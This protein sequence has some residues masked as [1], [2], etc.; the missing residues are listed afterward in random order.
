MN[1]STTQTALI[2][3]GIALSQV[4]P[5]LAQNSAP[6]GE[7]KTGIGTPAA[8]AA[9]RRPV[10]QDPGEFYLTAYRLC[11]E[12]EMLAS[13]QSYNAALRKGQQAEKVLAVIVRDFPHW[14]SNLV[15]TRRRIL[16]E[17]MAEY[18]RKAAAAPIPTGR[19]PGKPLDTD[20]SG[21][22]LPNRPKIADPTE[23]QSD[24]KPVELPDYES[25]DKDMYNALARAQE[26]CRRMAEAYKELNTR[27]LD[28]QKKLN[29]A[30]LDQK[31]YQDRYNQLQDQIK[32]ERAAGNRVVDALSQQLSELEAKYRAS[33]QA[34]KEA[35]SR[36]SELESKLAQTQAELER[37]TKERD[38]LKAENEQLRAIVE[39]NSPEKTKALLDQN[40][41]LAEQLKA[42]QEKVAQLESMQAGSD[43]QNAVLSRQL[44]EARNEAN[45][46]RDEMSGI[47]DENMGYR[48]RISELS[49]RLNNLEADLEAQSDQP[50]VD[51]ALAEENKLL[52]EVIAKQKRTLAMQEEGRKLLVETYMQIK[53][54]DPTMLIALKKLEEESTL[55]LTDAEKRIMESVKSAEVESS[56]SGTEGVDAVRRSLEVETLATLAGK[57]FAKGRYTSAEQLYRTLYDCQPDHVAGLVNLGTILLYRNKCEEAISFLERASRLAP[58]L[59]ITYYLTGICYYRMDKMTEAQKMFMRTVELDPGNAEAFFYLA[60][61]EGVNGVFDRALK[62][63]AAAIKL[64]PTLGDAHY[65]MARLYAEMSQIPD[66]ARAYDRAV[67]NGAEPDPEFENYLRNH[68]DNAKAPGVDLVAEVQPDAE[69]EILRKEDPEMEK[70]LAAREQEAAEQQADVN[71]QPGAEPPPADASAEPQPAPEQTTTPEQEPAAPSDQPAPPQAA[72]GESAPAG[73]PAPPAE[74]TPEQIFAGVVS[75]IQWDAKSAPSPSPAGAGHETDKSRFSTVRVYTYSGGWRHRVKLR[76]KRPE[77]QRLRQRGGEIRT[78]KQKQR[79]PSRRNRR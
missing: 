59:A 40:L 51:P 77:P 49:E 69:A 17:N 26:E 9:A 74:P 18:R 24:F 67:N 12:S 65:N 6:V 33:E 41:T 48:R 13:Q 75:K 27:F 68:P 34:R 55:D 58:D 43:D 57:A 21:L 71:V 15:S 37:V 28:T 52:R 2:M 45:R 47:Y 54:Q 23:Y 36:A 63:F 42:A 70:I 44:D 32:T 11:K 19:K 66:A 31:M 20:M 3:A 46:L 22:E 61:I 4:L 53:N 8:Q 25:S 14:K 35:E 76:L 73:E 62:H 64:K 5:L 38:A 29:V 30:L 50:V 1:L 10:V 7:G 60:N 72:P 16:A 79:K 78:L 39:L 56:D